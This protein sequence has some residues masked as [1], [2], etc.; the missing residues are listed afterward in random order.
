MAFTTFFF[1]F[2][3]M[4]KIV[5][6]YHHPSWLSPAE[7]L[8]I[9]I[10]FL[11]CVCCKQFFSSFRLP[12]QHAFTVYTCWL[13]SFPIKFILSSSPSPI[14]EMI[15]YFGIIFR[16]L[17]CRS[18]GGRGEGTAVEMG[19]LVI[20][21]FRKLSK[22]VPLR[23]FMS[24]PASMRSDRW[25][26]FSLPQQR[27]K[28]REAFRFSLFFW[29]HADDGGKTQKS[30][31]YVD[32]SGVGFTVVVGQQ[33]SLVRTELSAAV[34]LAVA[35]SQCTPLGKCLR[36]RPPTR[37][38]SWWIN[39]HMLR[40]H[41]ICHNLNYRKNFS[42]PLVR[43]FQNHTSFLLK[44]FPFSTFRCKPVKTKFFSSLPVPFLG[45]AH[46]RECSERE[47]WK[48]FPFRLQTNHQKG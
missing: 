2:T 39:I 30:Q 15:F 41:H 28:K 17:A 45:K 21:R 18:G 31:T 38:L 24:R 48:S 3:W 10:F 5:F 35:P 26:I 29:F 36:C 37:Y 22:Q 27:G 6:P 44:V 42:L 43:S 8:R 25:K 13:E 19:D 14:R 12:S 33:T 1:F 4:G 16:G 32:C 34:A 11:Y 7:A 9:I 23:N 20:K 46:A 47:W 40:S